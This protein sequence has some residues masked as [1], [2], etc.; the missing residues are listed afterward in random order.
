MQS[1]Y[2][3]LL[4][5]NFLL[6]SSL[7]NYRRIMSYRKWKA[8]WYNWQHG[9]TAPWNVPTSRGNILCWL[10]QGFKHIHHDVLGLVATYAMAYDCVVVRAYACCHLSRYIISVVFCSLIPLVV[11]ASLNSQYNWVSPWFRTTTCASPN[12]WSRGYE[13]GCLRLVGITQLQ[14]KSLE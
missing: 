8:I 14:L 2:V 6:C 5:F 11:S 7:S 4:Q 9:T 3:Q 1:W 12:L 13:P 10:C